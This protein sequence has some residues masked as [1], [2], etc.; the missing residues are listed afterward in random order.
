MMC[1][2]VLLALVGASVA[3]G[4]TFRGSNALYSG[5]QPE[6]VARTLQQVE[7]KW[8]AE[9]YSFVKCNP[10][11]ADC[12]GT[13]N[14]FSQSCSTVTSAIVQGS[15]GDK[16]S[17]LEYMDVVCS[18]KIQGMHKQHCMNLQK[19]LGQSMSADSYQNRQNFNPTKLCTSF[20]SEFVKEEKV[21]FTK[22]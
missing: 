22:E 18:Q 19:A 15:S 7:V 13:P 21:R 8:Q 9:A 1:R 3:N 17:A 10:A 16:K 11:E 6:V 14:A 4:K 5:M 2:L 12:S 20:W